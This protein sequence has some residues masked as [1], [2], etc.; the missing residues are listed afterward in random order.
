MRASAKKAAASTTAVRASRPQRSG[1][2][3]SE[4]G[5]GF[6]EWVTRL[7]HTHRERLYRLARREGLR[8]EDALDSVQ[9]AFHTFLLLPQAR[10]LVESDD[11]SL[12]LLSALV[13][14]HARNRRRRHEIARPHDSGE[15]ALAALAA[16]ESPVDELIAQAQEFALMVGC[17][18]T[19]GKLQRAIVSL[20]MLD[21]VPGEDVAVMLKLPPSHVAV[22]LHR[23]KQNL[24]SCMLS[25]GYRPGSYKPHPPGTSPRRAGAPERHL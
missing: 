15:E 17:I 12:K 25:A 20:R 3:A 1:A 10:Q 8:E 11:D 22:L 7:V 23:A 19:L 24:R 16:E 2:E 18:D 13:R 6:L 14:N 9:D 21:E 4:A 5:S